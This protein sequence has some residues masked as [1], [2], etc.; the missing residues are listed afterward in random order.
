M[1][2]SRTIIV[3][4]LVVAV[5][6]LVGTV[7]IASYLIGQE[8]RSP[9]R[10]DLV[11]ETPRMQALVD[12]AEE[13]ERLARE[14]PYATP[15]YRE[16]P[17]IGSRAAVW[18]LA[19]LHVFFAAFV[20]AVPLFAFVVEFIGYKTGDPRYDA[21]AREWIRLLSVAFALTAVLGAILLFML[22]LA[23]PEFTGYLLGA[24]P[25][26]FMAY[27][28]LF[29]LEGLLLYGYHHGWG[30][31]GPRLH[32]F[33]GCAL[34]LVGTVIL[35]VGTTWL[36]FMTSPA[37]V[38]E[39][40]ARIDAWRAIG[41]YAWAPVNIARILA[42]L[43]FGGAVAAAY[44]AF[45]FLYA[46]D[47]EERAHYDRMGY[48]GSLV[49][50]GA[51]LPLPFAGY[52]L[53]NEL[54]AL[55]ESMGLQVM[56]AE[57]PWVAILQAALIG[58]LF[59]GASYYA[60][61]G[62]E[63]IAGVAQYRSVI[64]YVMLVVALCFIAWATPRSIVSTVTEVH[65]MGDAGQLELGLRGVM[66]VKNT[67]LSLL[68]LSTLVGFLL[69]RRGG[70]R[71]THP[72]KSA[73]SRAQFGVFVLAA[74]IVVLLGIYGLF[75][76]PAARANLLIPQIVAVVLAT[77]LIAALDRFLLHD[78]ERTRDGTWGKIRP[79]SQYALIVVAVSYAWLL[80]LM[81]YVR[82]GLRQDW[83]VSAMTG[84]AAAEA[85]TPALGQATRVVS[86]TVIV[87]FVLIGIVFWLASLSSR[88]TWAASPSET[89]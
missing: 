36:T 53:A 19:Q 21:L 41:S 9:Y 48:T 82:S 56:G 52:W 49:T 5:L 89:T 73:V 55:S 68:I 61:V 10:V 40:S 29:L 26:T 47:D 46:K 22:A 17:L 60:W 50:I 57:F 15:A 18:V 14:T 24:F 81:G 83:Q 84:D 72:G 58:G 4:G 85:F 75:V 32:L 65:G 64:K 79:A 76:D 77:I 42:S 88:Q 62:L 11:D 37:G 67:A 59:L 23:Y 34:G 7:Q 20:L 66:S 78:T 54:F 43:A 2:M 38:A 25:R 63:R 16:I 12:E 13:A 27:L 1:P 30:R 8:Y 86:V 35:F 70:R 87:F 33:L 69:R 45:R 39:T 80:G 74:G 31:I 51:F 6:A 71:T 44:A 3:I 28:G